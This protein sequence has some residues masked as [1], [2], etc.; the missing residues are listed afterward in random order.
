MDNLNEIIAVLEEIKLEAVKVN[1]NQIKD[2][3]NLVLDMLTESTPD[4]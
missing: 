1:S 4:E 3:V 2:R